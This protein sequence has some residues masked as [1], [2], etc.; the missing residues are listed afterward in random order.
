MPGKLPEYILTFARTLRNKQT[1][2]ENLLWLMLRD[3]R[4][5]GFKFRREHP[6]GRYIIDFYCHE[7]KLAIELDGGGHNEDQTKEYDQLRSKELS[8]A[9]I[10]IERFWNNDVLSSLESVLE[11]I[12][13]AIQETSE[14]PS[15]A[16]SGHLLPEGEGITKKGF[17][18]V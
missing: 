11:H 8:G 12:Y 14:S 15:S 16:P 6:V 7:A 18:N 1:D 13:R 5:A 3:R 4:L 17:K 9:G 10:R 2:A